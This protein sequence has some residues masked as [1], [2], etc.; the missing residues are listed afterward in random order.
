LLRRQ[1]PD[2]LTTLAALAKPPQPH[3]VIQRPRRTYFSPQRDELVM[4]ED[5]RMDIHA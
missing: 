5:R 4:Q 3:Q 1:L 2:P